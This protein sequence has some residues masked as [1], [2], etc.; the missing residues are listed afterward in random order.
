MQ[1]DVDLTVSSHGMITVPFIGSVKAKGL[2]IPQLST[3]LG[4]RHVIEGSIRLDG[5]SLRITL[6]HINAETDAHIWAEDRI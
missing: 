1:Q 4:V 5:D 3:A 6:Q 2:T